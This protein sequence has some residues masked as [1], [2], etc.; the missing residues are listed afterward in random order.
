MTTDVII[1]GGGPAGAAASL[2][3]QQ[4]GIRSTIVEKDSFPRY[5]IGESMT[6]ECGN[7]IASLGLSDEMARGGHPVKWG[8]A[9]YGPQGSTPFYVP[10]KGRSAEGSLF[11]ASTWQVR[12]SKFDSMLLNT[13]VSRGADLIVGEAV[14]PI[15]SDGTVKG[16]QVRTG[17]SIAQLKAPLVIDASGQQTFLARSGITGRKK[18]GAYDNQVAIFSQ[19]SGADRGTGRSRDDTLIFYQKRHHWAW[20]IPL[21]DVT[22]SVGVVV[23][24]EYFAAKRESLKDFLGRELRELNPGLAARLL[25][26]TFSEEVRAISNYSYEVSDFTGPGFLCVGDSHRFI[27]PVFSFGMFFAIK[28]AQLAAEAASAWFSGGNR[29]S[30]PFVE[31]AR[32]ANNGMNTIQELIDA[33]WNQPVP[34]SVFVHSRYVEDCIDMFAG[35][36]YSPEPSPALLAFRKLNGRLSDPREAITRL[37]SLPI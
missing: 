25:T 19:V 35:R 6:G 24:K 13:A 15:V 9:V 12:R 28:E 11:E 21:D 16:V 31:Y 33:F 18:R 2:F 1:I 7:C 5:H 27:D 36:V 26:S 29:T 22:V 30:Q 34:F 3:L 17:G 23:P 20:F 4:R 32:T 8:T 10:V 37:P 14:A